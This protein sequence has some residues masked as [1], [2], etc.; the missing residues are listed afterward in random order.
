MQVALNEVEYVDGAYEDITSPTDSQGTPIPLEE[1]DLDE[2]QVRRWRE[3]SLERTAKAREL[4]LKQE[5]VLRNIQKKVAGKGD[6][7]SPSP[8]EVGSRC[9]LSR[10]TSSWSN[11]S[12][13]EG[14]TFDQQAVKVAELIVSKEEKIQSFSQRRK[15]NEAEVK[16]RQE[17]KQM[18]AEAA[19]Q[20]FAERMQQLSE[21]N[22]RRAFANAARRKEQQKVLKDAHRQH[23]RMCDAY[24]EN[25]SRERR[26]PEE[27]VSTKDDDLLASRTKSHHL[28]KDT[29]AGWQSKVDEND[30]KTEAFR[31]RLYQHATRRPRTLESL[32]RGKPSKFV[33]QSMSSLHSEPQADFNESFPASYS[34]T[35][36]VASIKDNLMEI[37]KGSGSF[38]LSS[39]SSQSKWFSR[40][41]HVKLFHEDLERKAIEK[42]QQ[43]EEHLNDARERISAIQRDVVSRAAERSRQ[44]AERNDSAATKRR[45]RAARSD[46]DL[47]K[48]QAEFEKRRQEEETKLAEERARIAAERS[49]RIQDAQATSEELY[50]KKLE[51]IRKDGEMRAA[52][53]ASKMA[54]K[55][56]MKPQPNDSYSELAKLTKERKLALDEDFRMKAEKEIQMKKS[57]S[58]QHLVELH[59][60][61]LE[62]QRTLKKVKTRLLHSS[63]TMSF[64]GG[65]P[66]MSFD[67]DEGLPFQDEANLQ[68]LVVKANDL[69]RSLSAVSITSSLPQS[70][71]GQKPG[72]S[73][74]RSSSHESFSSTGE[75][76]QD[77][78]D[79]EQRSTKW[80][81]TM[82][83]EKANSVSK[84]A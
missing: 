6:E 76:D 1:V 10:T 44:W 57:R 9:F 28:F 78:V 7:S 29:V 48:K 65:P 71:S 19:E 61:V 49:Q 41:Q 23:D 39:E 81:Q 14:S 31:S 15:D 32:A 16:R 75:Q 4:V 43:D 64:S 42:L 51:A 11:G 70:P 52:R 12:I 26:Q 56:Q 54:L 2:D 50:N 18:H 3:E 30:R 37:S 53:F 80:M 47:M 22:G 25:R 38:W 34:S 46:A 66:A 27:E 8:R 55:N 45:L 36:E 58:S 72:A 60:P 77:L 40:H 74:T 20:K 82:R 73:I 83:L 21:E 35:D 68:D 79:L 17:A 69:R 59:Q 5:E 33:T 24:N 13:Q 63:S 84:I 62:R 67:L